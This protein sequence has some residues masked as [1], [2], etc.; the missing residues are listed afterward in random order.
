MESLPRLF[1]WKEDLPPELLLPTSSPLP[2][3]PSKGKVKVDTFEPIQIE[4]VDGDYVAFY[5]ED[6]VE[7]SWTR[8]KSNARVLLEPIIYKFTDDMKDLGVAINIHD[9][10]DTNALVVGNCQCNTIFIPVNRKDKWIQCYFTTV[11]IDKNS[12]PETTQNGLVWVLTEQRGTVILDI[13]HRPDDMDEILVYSAIKAAETAVAAVAEEE[14]VAEGEVAVA[15]DAALAE[16]KENSVNLVEMKGTKFSEKTKTKEVTEEIIKLATNVTVTV[17][18]DKQLNETKVKGYDH[19]LNDENTVGNDHSIN[20]NTTSNASNAINTASYYSSNIKEDKQMNETKVKE[21]DHI[22]NDENIEGNDRSINSNTTGNT[23]NNTNSNAASNNTN[24]NTNTT[25]NITPAHEHNILNSNMKKNDETIPVKMK[26]NNEKIEEETSS[27]TTTT[28][29]KKRQSFPWDEDS[30]DT[31]TSN[32]SEDERPISPLKDLSKYSTSR[33]STSSGKCS[34]VFQIFRF[35]SF[36]P[37][38]KFEHS[39]EY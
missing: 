23:N 36:I 15:E 11:D 6:S 22:L 39:G 31:S 24:N 10:P 20:S 2:H 28:E 38:R 8:W 34:F 9:Q 4:K 30:I 5:P 13:E 7:L 27:S 1:Q 12:S 18:E 14:A 32:T 37:I 19:I 33:D 25:N 26:G 21:Y 17:K 35:S 29:I 16:E 3:S